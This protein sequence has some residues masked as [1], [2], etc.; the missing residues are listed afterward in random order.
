MA[1]VNLTQ[2]GISIGGFVIK[3]EFIRVKCLDREDIKSLGWDHEEGSFRIKDAFQGN[4]LLKP[5][6]IQDII[7]CCYFLVTDENGKTIQSFR[8]FI[9]NKS[10]L[11]HLMKQLGIWK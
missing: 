9:K 3:K 2:Q 5:L 8:L 10:E 7:Q 1:S 4:F 6:I 11:K